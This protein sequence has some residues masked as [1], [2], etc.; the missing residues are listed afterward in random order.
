MSMRE[1]VAE[2]LVSLR[3]DVTRSE[4]AD[5][6]GIS[7]QAVMKLEQGSVSLERLDELAG[8]YGVEFHLVATLPGTR[9]TA[10]SVGSP[11]PGLRDLVS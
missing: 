2:L 11:A 4:F 1:E 3:G 10:R 6:L 7:R 5:R 9:P 8:V